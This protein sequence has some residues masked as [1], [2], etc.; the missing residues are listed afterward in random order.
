MDINLGN[1]EIGPSQFSNFT[2]IELPEGVKG[3]GMADGNLI[4]VSTRDLTEEEKSKLISDFKSLPPENINKIQRATRK[5][6]LITK[7][8]INKSDI[9]A[10]VELIQD[11]N[12]D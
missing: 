12:D 4:V 3:F 1:V 9:K 10:L 5:K 2:Q 8:G 6:Q 11:G 7:L